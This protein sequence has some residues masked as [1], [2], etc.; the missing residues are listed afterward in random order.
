[1]INGFVLMVPFFPSMIYDK[2][3]NYDLKFCPNR[4]NGA[5]TVRPTTLGSAPQSMTALTTMTL[6]YVVK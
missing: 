4:S 3:R 1:M 2:R 6:S 5:M